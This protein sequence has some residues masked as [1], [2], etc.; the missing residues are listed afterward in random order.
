LCRAAHEHGAHDFR[1]RLL[2]LDPSVKLHYLDYL[3]RRFPELAE[4]QEALYARGAH[5]DR[6]YANDLDRAV[7][8]V[9][10]RYVFPADRE[11]PSPVP[12]P[13]PAPAQLTLSLA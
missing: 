2:K 4:R 11:E 6:S 3:R 7:A 13:E 8:R 9:R 5:A 1:H 12:A 10:A